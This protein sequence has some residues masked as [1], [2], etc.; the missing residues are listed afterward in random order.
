M[1]SNEKIKIRSLK[2]GSWYWINKELL[3]NYGQ[4]IS[5]SG[6]AVYNVLA[7]Y[8]NS[9]TQSCFPSQKKIADEIGIS[10]KTVRDKIREL[11]LFGL[12]YTKSKNCS[13]I[14]TL[15]KIRGASRSTG[16]DESSPKGGT[17]CYT[18]DNKGK[19]YNNDNRSFKNSIIQNKKKFIPKTKED[20]LALDMAQSLNDMDGL[21]F[22]RTIAKKHPESLL[23]KLLGDV[24]EIPL[25]RIKRSRKSYFNY[26]IQKHDKGSN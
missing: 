4:K 12:L 8:A 24:K 5:S 3:K 22:Y 20:L 16:W 25:E 7:K 21:S 26:L 9:A 10:R 23:R 13:R 19:I 11:E 14:Y 2:D 17:R 1:D 18:K 15:L 6:I